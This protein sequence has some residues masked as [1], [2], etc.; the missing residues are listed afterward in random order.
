MQLLFS[1][2]DRKNIV[3]NYHFS[4]KYIPV[5]LRL[6]YRKNGEFFRL[7][8][9]LS[10]SFKNPTKYSSLA[11]K[12]TSKI[13]RITHVHYITNFANLSPYIDT[14]IALARAK[15]LRISPSAKKHFFSNRQ[16][17]ILRHEPPKNS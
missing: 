8:S 2:S 17:Y 6:K 1:L 12:N 3:L 14:Q 13:V 11:V 16:T 5:K 10:M 15:N 4:L 7:S 9:N